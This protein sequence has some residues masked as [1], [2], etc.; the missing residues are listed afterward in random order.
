MNEL[1]DK[2]KHQKLGKKGKCHSEKC[3]FVSWF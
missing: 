2:S 3:Y 1:T